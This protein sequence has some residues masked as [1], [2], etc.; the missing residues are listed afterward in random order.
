MSLGEFF[1]ILLIVNIIFLS[2]TWLLNKKK[3]DSNID[4][5]S[6]GFSLI[7][8]AWSAIFVNLLFNDTD[9][10]LRQWLITVLV[11]IWG[12]K[13]TL[14]IFST[15]EQKKDLNSDNLSLD[16]YLKKVPRRVIFQMLI[17]SPVI[18]VNFLPGPSGLNFLDFMGVLIFS[19]GL[20]Y[21]IYSNKEL[22]HFKSKSTNEQK[23]FIEGL[24]SFSRHPNYLGKL[25]QW[26]SLYIIALSAVFGYWSIYGPI[27]YTFYLSS[28]VN[29]Q[30][31]KLKIKYKGYLNYSK[32]TNKLFP[33]ILFLMQLFLPQRFLTS[34]FGYLTNSKIKILKSFLIKLFFF[35]YKPDLTE[36]ELSNP[37]EYSSFNH[38]FTRRLKPNSR[39][40]KSAAKVIISPVDGEI[41]DFGNLSKGKLIQAKKYKYDIYELL[42]E[43]QTTKIFDKGSFISIYLA[44]KNYHR[45]HFPYGGKISKT[46]H[47]PGS[48]LSVNKRSQIS[49]PSLYTKNERAWVSVTSEGFSYLV[50]CVG[51]F[52][53]GS[54][55]PFWASDISKKTTQLISS[56]NNG[57]SKEL[58]S[59]DKAQ[60]L[61]FF[62]MGSTIILIFSNEF[63]LNNNFLSANKSVKFGETMV[64]I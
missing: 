26:W 27:I 10:K 3:R 56:W 57:P 14:D 5:V 58:N 7:V 21:E 61:G 6:Q 18:S 49:I 22:T 25:I 33:E 13:L 38:L 47:I 29:S 42:D 20:L 36:A 54:I 46:K 24:W 31:S 32:V 62:Q 19:T 43:K 55:V 50:V 28:Y 39:A 51:A 64:E 45:I 15:K 2:T 8:L 44:P 9:I 11:T 17:I 30:E 35:I 52:M 41:T 12:L 34:V 48:L 40:F 23:I 1:I 53:V 4:F 59:V 37:Q 63:K 16:L 60:E